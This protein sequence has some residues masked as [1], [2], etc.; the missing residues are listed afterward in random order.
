MKY[1]KYGNIGGIGRVID[2]EINPNS[3]YYDSLIDLLESEVYSEHTIEGFRI[4]RYGFDDRL[5]KNV[6]MVL[7]D[8]GEYKQQFVCYFI[9]EN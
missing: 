6:Y 5:N 4:K 8:R 1:F 9:E 7:H 2:R 3:G